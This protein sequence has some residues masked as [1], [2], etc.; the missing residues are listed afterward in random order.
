MFP[1]FI[2]IATYFTQAFTTGNFTITHF[3]LIPHDLMGP[4]SNLALTLAPLF[5]IAVLP[6]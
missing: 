5:G 6:G 2:E 4:L 1:M 3:S